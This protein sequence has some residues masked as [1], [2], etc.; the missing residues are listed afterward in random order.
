MSERKIKSREKNWKGKY[1]DKCKNILHIMLDSL[2]QRFPTSGPW[3]STGPWPVRNWA[4]QQEVSGRQV[5]EASS[6]FTATPHCSHYC[7]SSA[8]CQISSGIRFS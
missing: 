3:T 2:K 1:L 7:L 6:V 4:A 8:F 5:S